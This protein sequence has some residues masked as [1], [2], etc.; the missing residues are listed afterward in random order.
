MIYI[1]TITLY[2]QKPSKSMPRKMPTADNFRVKTI[3]RMDRRK[4]GKNVTSLADAS[5]YVLAKYLVHIAKTFATIQWALCSK[6]NNL[7]QAKDLLQQAPPRIRMKIFDCIF[8]SSDLTELV[9]GLS[10]N[11]ISTKVYIL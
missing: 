3:K 7:I 1:L 4:H 6:D 9:Y 8:E 5:T 11:V 10:G 2:F